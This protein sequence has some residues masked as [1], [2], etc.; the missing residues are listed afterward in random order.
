VLARPPIDAATIHLMYGRY[1]SFLPAEA[2]A[3]IFGTRNPLLKLAR[4]WNVA[5]S[6]KGAAS[7]QT[8]PR[9]THRCTMIAIER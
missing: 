3:R 9:V 4:S 6:R 8:P 2:I 1:A 7:E 5:P